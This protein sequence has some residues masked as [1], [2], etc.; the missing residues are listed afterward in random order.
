MNC[1]CAIPEAGFPRPADSLSDGVAVAGV[2]LRVPGDAKLLVEVLNRI[3][4]VVHD[5]LSSVE[6]CGFGFGRHFPEDEQAFL[7]HIN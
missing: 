6:W 1:A 3:S 5:E 4:V 2:I 7:I